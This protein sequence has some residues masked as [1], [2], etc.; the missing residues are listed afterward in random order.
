MIHEYGYGPFK[1][2]PN[3]R[4]SIYEIQTN[5][6]WYMAQ[7]FYDWDVITSELLLC[8][9]GHLYTPVTMRNFQSEFHDLIEIRQECL[10]RNITIE[11]YWAQNEPDLYQAQIEKEKEDEEFVLTAIKEEDRFDNIENT[12]TARK[13][14]QKWQEKPWNH[15]WYT[16][17]NSV[18]SSE[19]EKWKKR[20]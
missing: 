11:T 15:K 13:A 8:Y 6:Y 16:Q 14:I 1:K 20:R 7:N 3:E 12:P 2:L 10:E 9:P 4:R 19:M 5:G 17:D 18:T